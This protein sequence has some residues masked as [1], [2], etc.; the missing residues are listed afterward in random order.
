MNNLTTTKVLGVN[1]TNAKKDDILEYVV[2]KLTKRSKTRKGKFFIVTPNP[3]IVVR[4]NRDENFK[5]VLNSAEISLADGVGVV[6]ASKILG[7]AI[8][9]R[10]TGADF[11]ENLCLKL[12]KQPVITGF[13]GGVPGVAEMAAECLREK[14][15]GLKVGYAYHTWEKKRLQ[16]KKLDILFVAF[17][18]P[19]QEEWMYEHIQ[20][21]DVFCA[22]GVGGSFDFITGRVS[23]AP[24]AVRR[25][26]LEW[27]FRLLVQPW[28]W[29]RQLALL[30]FMGLVIK[31][32]FSPKTTSN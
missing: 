22:M 28:R 30:T 18:A 16:D 19:I 4:A 24:E 32:K 10:I 12:S 15:P 21:E 9:A 14:Y 13:L 2:G 11:M 7:E 20:K 26:G 25:L 31:A 3:E 5:N 29:K 6:I 1:F 27:L 17:G 23:R 8:Q